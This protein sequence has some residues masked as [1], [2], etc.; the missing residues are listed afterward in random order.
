MIEILSIFSQFLIFL[1]IFSFPFNPKNLANT[2]K[3]KFSSI[4]ILDSHCINIIFFCYSALIFSFLNFDLKIIFKIY[5]LLSLI[6]IFLNFKNYSSY[7]KRSEI[8]VFLTFSLLVISIFFSVAQNLKLEWDGHHWLEKALVFFNGDDIEKLKDVARHP[9]Y[10]HLSSYLWAFF[11]K[12]SFL[13]LEYFGRYFHIYF[14]VITVFLIFNSLDLKK[15]QIKISLIL[16]F[17]LIT[18]EP[19]LLAG[20]QE[21]LIFSTL[22]IATR[23]IS[24]IDFKKFDNLR[25]IYLIIF[26]LYLNSWFKDEG[27]IYFLIFSITLVCLLNISNLSKIS[28]CFLIL[29]LLILQFFLQK[30][31]IGVYD[32]PQRTS[33]TDVFSEILN[34]NILLTKLSKILIHCFIAFIKYPLWL[35]IFVSIFFLFYSTKKFNPNTKYLLICLSINMLFILSIFL[36]FKSFDFMLKVSLDR[37]LFQTSSFFIPL[38]L[39]LINNFKLF[40]K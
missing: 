17:I 7:F 28:F 20:Y 24:L 26:I 16:F 22:I 11:W 5:F 40:K 19:Y 38:F 30:Y 31:F 35:I 1:V 29:G 23:Y 21:Y 37:L 32:F 10:P 34:L 36:T 33:L 3:I 4:S 9:E 8:F 12:N 39:F 13:E 15:K 2:F 25:L 18:Y 14:Y 6:F 27:L